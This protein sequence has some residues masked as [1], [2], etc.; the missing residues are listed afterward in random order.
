MSDRS[1]QQTVIL[2]AIITVF[3]FA[4]LP[5]SVCTSLATPLTH[6]LVYF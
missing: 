2:V 5:S 1:G 3:Y 4:S 6:T